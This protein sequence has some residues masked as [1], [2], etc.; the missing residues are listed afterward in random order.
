VKAPAS[1]RT[2]RTDADLG[3]TIARF[4]CIYGQTGNLQAGDILLN[5][6]KSR[7]WFDCSVPMGEMRQC[8]H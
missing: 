1:L 5:R 2:F 4:A 3:S 8:K 6:N 7:A